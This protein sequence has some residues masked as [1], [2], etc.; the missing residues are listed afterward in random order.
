MNAADT[1]SALAGFNRRWGARLEQ[2]RRHAGPPWWAPGLILDADIRD[3]HERYLPVRAFLNDLAD[4]ATHILP[5]SSWVP[6]LLRPACAVCACCAAPAPVPSLPDLWAQL[7]E[8]LAGQVTVAESALLPLLCALADPP[9]FGTDFGRYP[10]QLRGIAEF[11]TTH[12]SPGVPLRVLDL[13]CGTGQGTREAAATV[14]AA[15]GQTPWTVGVTSEPLEVWMATHRR[16]PHDPAREQRLQ[17]CLAPCPVHFLAG[18][19]TAVPC[20]GRFDLVLANGL[21]GGPFLR[22]PHQVALFLLELARLL[23]PNGRV[24]LANRFHEGELPQVAAAAD[25]ARRYGWTVA[26]DP[27]LLWLSRNEKP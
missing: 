4:L 12:V 5:H 19:A 22:S 14:A 8:P 2:F 6:R 25:I 21:V 18:D 15:T 13:G 26:G 16:L 20:R 27:R 1:Q 24:T 10:E 23:A 9:R 17:A 11:A 3:R 7:P